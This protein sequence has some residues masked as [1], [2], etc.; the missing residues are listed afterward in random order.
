MFICMT[1]CT[2]AFMCFPKYINSANEVEDFQQVV[3]LIEVN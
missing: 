1:L 3:V 2:Y